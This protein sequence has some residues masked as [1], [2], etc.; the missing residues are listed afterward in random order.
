MSLN[1]PTSPKE[2]GLDELK[3]KLNEFIEQSSVTQFDGED[4]VQLIEEGESVDWI[5]G[6][7][8]GN[9]PDIDV[10]EISVLLTKVRTLIAPEGTVQPGEEAEATEAAGESAAE[11]E[12]EMP[13]LSPT[14]L[15]E[16]DLS[17]LGDILPPGTDV[18]ELK[19]LI[20]SPQGKV[21]TDFFLFCQ[22]KG[23]ELG[24]GSLD[25]PRTQELQNEWK[26]TPRD[27]FDGK[28]PAEM[29]EGS[30]AFTQEKVETYRRAEPRV[31]RN[32]PCPCGSGKKFKK[33]CGRV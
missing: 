6:Q 17:H 33:C 10:S 31:G 28:T 22:E 7:L 32:D 18:G 24:E 3:S 25:D 8:R 4:L 1:E 2:N 29:M 23:F 27:A 19:K 14:D 12:M 5:V 15:A 16:M 21:M 26:S 13:D 9:R 20:E 30:P 11:P